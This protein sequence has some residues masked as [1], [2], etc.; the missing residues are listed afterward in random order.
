LEKYE[1]NQIKENGK[2][3]TEMKNNTLQTNLVDTKMFASGGGTLRRQDSLSKRDK[4]RNIMQE[5]LRKINR[6]D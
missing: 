1:Q 3:A 6:I 4:P 2:K 5:Q